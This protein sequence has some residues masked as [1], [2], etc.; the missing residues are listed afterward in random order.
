MGDKSNKTSVVPSRKPLKFTP[1]VPPH[2]RAKPA[3]T[4]MK[5]LNEAENIVDKELLQRLKLSHE[6]LGR[7]SAKTPR[8]LKPMHINGGESTSIR[9]FGISPGS[10]DGSKHQDSSD[11]DTPLSKKKYVQPWKKDSYIPVTLPLRMSDDIDPEVLDEEE[12]GEASASLTQDETCIKPAE[13]LG[14]LEESEKK[15]RMLFFQLPA[16]FPFKKLPAVGGRGKEI[17]GQKSALEKGCGLQEL[18]A[19]F[20]GKMMVYKSSIV[21]MKLGDTLFDVSP[22]VNCIFP[23]DVAA[24]N[25]KEKHCCILGN[26]DRHV[27]VTPDLDSLL[28]G[29]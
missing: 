2:K 9:S 17:E 25:T 8:K 29:I 7:K 11:M 1:K 24:I 22:G 26:I 14:L 27:V 16:S 19:G 6:G 21:K 5:P 4:D 3:I 18:P 13:E 28:D 20:M 10:I 23:Q 15:P 12:F